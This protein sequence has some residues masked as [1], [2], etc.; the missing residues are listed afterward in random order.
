M[1]FVYERDLRLNIQNDTD[2]DQQIYLL[3]TNFILVKRLITNKKYIGCV[4]KR[5]MWD[6]LIV[7]LTEHNFKI[8]LFLNAGFKGQNLISPINLQANGLQK[9][10][11]AN[12]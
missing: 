1:N 3:Y 9:I 7:I 11:S 8:K 5:K 4:L 12:I 10:Q 6:Y 2:S